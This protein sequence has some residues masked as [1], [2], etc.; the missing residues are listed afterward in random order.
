MRLLTWILAICAG[1]AAA[2][3]PIAYP[4]RNVQIIVPFTPGASADILARLLG[5][6]LGERWNVAV[7]AD[8][9]PGAS[10]AIGIAHAAK[11]APDGHTLLFVA[12]SFGMV[13]VLQ[14]KL[15]YHPVKSFTPVALMS[16]SDLSL[17]VH[18]VLPVGSVQEF[19]RLAKRRPGE[20]HYSSPGNGTPQHLL[21]E[22]FK[23]ETGLD[24]VHV[25][26]RGL[27]LA[28][29]DLVGGHVQLMISTLQTI[30]PHITSG[31]LR[32]LAVLSATRSDTFP[33]VPTLREQGWKELEVET[34]YGALVPASTPAAIV[35]K[36]NADINSVLQLAEIRA[37]LV[38]LGMRIE[39][40]PPERFDAR[41]K[42]E[43]ARWTRVVAAAK[44]KPD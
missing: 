15:P 30:Q 38:K 10:G 8:N 9:R 1:A 7:I 42:A 17:V 37:H 44:I 28:I 25:P 31:R 20:L 35:A 12:T 11:A 34:W 4:S 43:L 16:T 39:S 23:L 40:G 36:L 33:Q 18:P 19:V 41:I 6:K 24:L 22:L 26:Y 32:M 27:S 21:M 5:P 14:S 29:N 2:Q 3:D 13:S